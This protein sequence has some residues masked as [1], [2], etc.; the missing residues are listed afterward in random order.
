MQESKPKKILKIIIIII[1]LL[2]LLLLLF[3]WV[4]TM[5][6]NQNNKIV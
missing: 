5:C 1:I 3:K 6:K 4:G 2:L